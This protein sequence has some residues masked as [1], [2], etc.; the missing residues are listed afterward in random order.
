MTIGETRRAESWQLRRTTASSHQLRAL[1]ITPTE[2][3]NPTYLVSFSQTKNPTYL[4][5]F[6]QAGAVVFYALLLRFM[7]K[8]S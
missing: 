2:C 8:Y 6:S 4:V 1:A 7:Q 3:Q 5:M